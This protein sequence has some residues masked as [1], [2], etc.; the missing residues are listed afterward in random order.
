MSMLDTF[1][2]AVKEPIF[3]E[4]IGFFDYEIVGIWI[5]AT[6]GLLTQLAADPRTR[7]AKNFRTFLL[8]V[9][10]LGIFIGLA[11]VILFMSEA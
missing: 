5:I 9:F 4:A 7:R 10:S 8:M 11:K 6:F 2:E 3:P 1:L